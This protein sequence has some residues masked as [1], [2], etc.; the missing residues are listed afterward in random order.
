MKPYIG[1]TGFKTQP[2]VAEAAQ[3]FGEHLQYTEYI[4]MFGFI[5]SNKRL[6]NWD[7]GGTN[8]PAAKELTTLTALVSNEYLPMIHYYTPN[9]DTLAQEIKTLFTETGLYTSCQA[10]QLNVHWPDQNQLELIKKDFPD[11]HIVLQLKKQA[12]EEPLNEL[13]KKTKAYDGLVE[14]VLVDPSGGTGEDFDLSNCT[15][16]MK[17]VQYVLP[18]TCIG[19]AGGLSGENVYERMKS[20]ATIV[21]QDFCVDAQGKLRIELFGESLLSLEKVKKY[22]E[23]AA[24]AVKEK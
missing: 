12:L 2:E 14:Y 16:I 10:V 7:V 17:S 13:I 8:S 5:A 15:I 24:K 20:V 1:I 9:R 22:I 4:A 23:N 3:L 11:M 19:I 21:K 18:R 6:A